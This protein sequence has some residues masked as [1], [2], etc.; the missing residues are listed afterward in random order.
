LFGLIKDVGDFVGLFSFLA[1]AALLVLYL[2]R[3]RELRGLRRS[4][5]FLVN[6]GNGRG[7]ARSRRAAAPAGRRRS[8]GR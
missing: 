6:A 5:P 8:P 7:N 1:M 2:L 4:A 3:A